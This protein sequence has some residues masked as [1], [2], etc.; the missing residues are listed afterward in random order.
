MDNLLKGVSTI[1]FCDETKF[2]KNNGDLENEIY[3]FGISCKKEHIQ[4]INYQLNSLYSKHKLQTKI[5][6]STT[7]F[8]EKRP[9][10]LLIQDLTDLIIDNQLICF[11]YK[12]LEPRLFDPTK[13]LNKFNNDILDFNKVEFQALFYFIT[14]LNTYLRDIAPMLIAKEISMY[15]DRNVYGKKDVE[16]FNFPSADFVLKQMTFCEKSKISLLALPDF[17]G[18][19]FRKSKISNNRVQNGN[20]SIETSALTISCYENL[21]KINTA[22]LFRFID[23]KEET[24]L[25]ALKIM[26]KKNNS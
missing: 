10:T 8:K 23:I 13:I 3:Y 14:T 20:N 25:K 24:T 2:H 21:I 5:F 12:Y 22:G 19:I 7:I 26:S 6:H 18:Y 9:R 11:C 16:A 1:L 17:F 15:F 4:K